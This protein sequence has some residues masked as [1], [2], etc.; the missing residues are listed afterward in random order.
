MLVLAIESEQLQ[1]LFH[2][3]DEK[4]VLASLRLALEVERVPVEAVFILRPVGGLVLGEENPQRR[5]AAGRE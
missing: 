1:F 2:M 5:I 4:V 3:V